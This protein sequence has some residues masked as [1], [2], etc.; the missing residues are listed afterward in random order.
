[1]SI[2]TCTASLRRSSTAS[3]LLQEHYD[4]FELRQNGI[5]AMDDALAKGDGV[6]MIGAHLGSFEAL[7]ALGRGN[8]IRVAL[9][10]YEDNARALNAA[11]TALAP[12][13]QIHTIA[14]GRLDAMLSL[15]RWL[16]SGA[17]RRAAR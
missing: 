4:Q 17:H 15:R 6:L 16:D 8:G 7:R 13:T 11:L 14:L 9:I 12:G 3:Y 10:M 5:E 1:M 2:A